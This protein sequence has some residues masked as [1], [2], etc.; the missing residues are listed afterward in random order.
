MAKNNWGVLIPDPQNRTIVPA[1]ILQID[2]DATDADLDKYDWVWINMND[3]R[4]CPDCERLALL[5]PAPFTEWINERTEPGRGDTICGD[6][7]RC[8]LVPDA[9]RT[10]PDMIAGEP[11]K[12]SGDGDLVI[13]MSTPYALF[14]ELDDWIMRYKHA[15]GFAKLT[16]EYYEVSTVRGRIDWL[17]GFL[18]E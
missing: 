13:D 2:M 3:D 18:G 4:V 1:D 7:C 11:I 14:E 12:L 5:S 9:I 16:P 8:L 6:R 10:A 15:T 17:K